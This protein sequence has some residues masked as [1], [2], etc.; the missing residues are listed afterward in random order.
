MRAT[1]LHLSKPKPNICPSLKNS[2]WGYIRGR[3]YLDQEE[4][5]PEGWQASG[6]LDIL[7]LGVDLRRAHQALVVAEDFLLHVLHFHEAKREKLFQAGEK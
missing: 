1:L 7:V 4:V 5:D 6:Q 2:Y 3:T